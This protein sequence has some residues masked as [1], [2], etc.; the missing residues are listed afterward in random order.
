MATNDDQKN[1]NSNELHNLLISAILYNAFFDNFNKMEGAYTFEIHK[2]YNKI[3]GFA[4][5]YNS[6]FNSLLITTMIY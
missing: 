4:N 5:K 3:L 1:I 6:R 2:F